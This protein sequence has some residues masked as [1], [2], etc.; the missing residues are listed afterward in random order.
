[1]TTPCTTTWAIRTINHPISVPFSV[2]P[3]SF[4]TLADA[5]L[6]D[7]PP[8]LVSTNAQASP[9]EGEKEREREREREREEEEEDDD[10]QLVQVLHRCMHCLHA[11]CELCFV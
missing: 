10:Q 6:D 3:R 1:M 11:D 8:K 4:L 7:L 2:D 5:A 9:R